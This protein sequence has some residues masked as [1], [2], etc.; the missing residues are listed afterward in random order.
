MA[1]KDE[2]YPERITERK[3]LF[4]GKRELPSELSIYVDDVRNL[5]VN[6]F[7][8]YHGR[9]ISSVERI[10]TYSDGENLKIYVSDAGFVEGVNVFD[11]K[12]NRLKTLIGIYDFCS[13]DLENLSQP[14]E[15]RQ[16]P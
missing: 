3:V 8:K 1:D 10:V 7:H 11:I 12:G 14:R 6:T 9:K 13:E 2:I 5:P 4:S 16:N 15:Q